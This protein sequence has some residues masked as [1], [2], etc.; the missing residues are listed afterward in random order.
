MSS[1][2]K[3]KGGVDLKNLPKTSDFKKWKETFLV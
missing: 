2:K 3:K 1:V